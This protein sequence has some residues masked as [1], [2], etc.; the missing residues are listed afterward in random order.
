M[1]QNEMSEQ[2][3]TVY[4]GHVVKG[5]CYQG[6]LPS[7]FQVWVN[8]TYQV[9]DSASFAL[10]GADTAKRNGGQFNEALAISTHSMVNWGSVPYFDRRE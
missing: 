10:L 2:S 5:F 4:G 3:I 9:S 8:K 6:Q 7:I 1:A